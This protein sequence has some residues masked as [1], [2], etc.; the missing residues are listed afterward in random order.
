MQRGVDPRE[1]CTGSA[2]GGAC[3]GLPS[4]TQG[5][6]D[7]DKQQLILDF[8]LATNDMFQD[9]AN[10]PSSEIARAFLQVARSCPCPCGC[11]PRHATGA[12][13]LRSQ[14]RKTIGI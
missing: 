11:L 4:P 12:V 8:L 2:A 7:D 1:A 6:T 10:Q 9:V 13:L 5:P 3:A 14:C